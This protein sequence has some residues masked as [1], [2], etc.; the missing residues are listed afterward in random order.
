MKRSFLAIAAFASTAL[1]ATGPAWAHAK[2]VSSTP[3]ANASLSAAP[4]TITLTFNERLVPA[5]SK[6]EL[7]MPAHNNMKVPVKTSVSDDG[8]S[9]AVAPQQALAKGTYKIVWSA[10]TS[11]GHKMNGEVPFR[12]S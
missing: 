12:V 11:D 4:R 2:L 6:A 1:L 5:F 9:I 8:K 10:A 3:P 7:V